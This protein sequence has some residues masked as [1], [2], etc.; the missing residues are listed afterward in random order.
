[1]HK[2]LSNYVAEKGY[3]CYDGILKSFS[4]NT[5]LTGCCSKDKMPGE[6]IFCTEK[7]SDMATWFFCSFSSVF[8]RMQTIASL[9]CF[10]S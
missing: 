6:R 4:K 1:M 2:T 10:N 9:D 3:L 8:L 7:C 5:D